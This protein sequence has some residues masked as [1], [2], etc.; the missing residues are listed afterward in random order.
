MNRENN[1][2]L[3]IVFVSTC[4]T[5]SLQDQSCHYD[6]VSD[7]KLSTAWLCTVEM[8]VFEKYRNYFFPV[9]AVLGI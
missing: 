4:V 5:L 9:A 6:L 8:K 1:Q 3:Y 2:I 7:I